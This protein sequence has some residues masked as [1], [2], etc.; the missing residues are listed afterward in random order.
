M[1]PQDALN[2]SVPAP[3]HRPERRKA[4]LTKKLIVEL[5]RKYPIVEA[6]CAKADVSRT[7]HYEWMRND[8]RYRSSVEEAIKMS[9]DTVTDIAES[10]IIGGVKK[11]EFKASS[12]WLIHRD[13][14]YKPRD[15]SEKPVIER[16][17]VKP[18]PS[19]ETVE[20]IKKYNPKYRP[21]TKEEYVTEAEWER[22]VEEDK[23]MRGCAVDLERM[24]EVM[25]EISNMTKPPERKL[26][27]E[28][29]GEPV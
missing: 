14:R 23:N 1:D 22:Q 13:P 21:P 10:N 24:R 5:L 7:T 2:R 18:V 27:D 29:S 11:G 17:M 25:L 12:F 3:E 28:N 15:R 4:K 20:Q 8:A 6:A 9:S 26:P 16:L 19:P